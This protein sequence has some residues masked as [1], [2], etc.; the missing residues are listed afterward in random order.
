M[1]QQN[2]G[3]GLPPNFIANLPTVPQASYTPHGGKNGLE[4]LLAQTVP[5]NQVFTGSKKTTYG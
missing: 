2:S 3:G 4:N 5:P 1:A